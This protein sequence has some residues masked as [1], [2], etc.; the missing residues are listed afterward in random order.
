V[1]LIAAGVIVG[2][3]LLGGV[4]R[5]VSGTGSPSSS[6]PAVVPTASPFM[7]PDPSSG[8]AVAPSGTPRATPTA[9]HATSTPKPSTASKLLPVKGSGRDAGTEIRM[10]PGPEG[11]VY[12][13]V[14]AKA[15]IR[16]GGSVVALLDK[17]GQPRAGWPIRLSGVDSC[18]LLLAASD[19][20]VRVV[21]F[22]PNQEEGLNGAVRRAFAFDSGGLALPGWPV[23]VGDAFTGR[24]IG[25]DLTMVERPYYGDVVEEGTPED[26]V[27]LVVIRAGGRVEQGSEVSFAECCQSTWAVGPNGIAYGT[28]R[29]D[30]ETKDSV[31]TDVIAFDLAGVQPGWP[32]TIDGNTSDTAFDARGLAYLVVGWPTERPA[33][34]VV[35]DGGGKVHASGSADQAIVSTATWNGAGDDYPGP[36]TVA[37]DGSAF[38]LS[39]EGGRTTI[40]AL[41]PNGQPRTGWPYRSSLG[42][43][44]TGFCGT[45]DTGCG[46]SRTMPAVGQ[47]NVLYLLQAASTSGGGSIVAIGTDG[48]VRA[49]WPV[50]LK[51]AGS[52][53]WS[54]VVNPAGGVWALAIEP[55]TPGHSATI[56]SIANDSTVRFATTVVEP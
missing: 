42:M 21:C 23:D 18:D 53:F 4:A 29:R 25:T 27:N 17:G 22:V 3:L 44:W 56:L 52:A 13:S 1:A 26:I 45:G 47:A 20:S 11:G 46:Q 15:G 33:R 55:E 2:G 14:P 28:Y 41:D 36:P 31:K 7:T 34:T 54:V 32:V 10:A 43:Q 39:T 35:L 49:G 16:G 40:L 38:I 5:F 24:V 12:V 19:G 50:G 51:R 37:A 9:A 30:F 48:R 6:S 8:S